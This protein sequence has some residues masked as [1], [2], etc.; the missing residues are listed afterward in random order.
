M[1]LPTGDNNMC[2]HQ[3]KTC[4]I[5][6]EVGRFPAF[7]RMTGGAICTQL[8]SVWVICPMTRKTTFRC[9]LQIR[10]VARAEMTLRAQRQD[11]TARQ[12]KHKSAVR[13]I[14][15]VG[16]QAIVTTQ[17]R[18]S[19]SDVVIEHERWIDLIMTGFT[20]GRIE[21]RDILPMTIATQK[22]LVLG[23]GLMTV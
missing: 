20:H 3:F 15:P 16:I 23:L 4:A 17:A 12:R 2:S 8:A 11:M 5:M 6:I 7:R 21:R 13:K 9:R 1:A 22:R 19:K 18:P 10:N 14:V